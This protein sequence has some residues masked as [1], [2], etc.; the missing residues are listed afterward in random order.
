MYSNNFSDV[1]VAPG[2]AGAALLED[3][4]GAL[5]FAQCFVGM[6]AVSSSRFRFAVDVL[7]VSRPLSSLSRFRFGISV[8]IPGMS[9]V[10]FSCFLSAAAPTSVSGSL[11]PALCF[12][13]AVISEILAL[14]LAGLRA[15][16]SACVAATR[17]TAFLAMPR[18]RRC[19][20]PQVSHTWSPFREAFCESHV[21]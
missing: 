16:T 10:S 8:Q 21:W 14:T 20:L 19:R 18:S 5:L 17:S 6:S 15:A 1:C 11:F 12:R 2:S 13:F 4:S 7:A 9:V 3:C